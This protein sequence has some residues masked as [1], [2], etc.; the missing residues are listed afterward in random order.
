MP[1]RDLGSYLGGGGWP[2]VGEPTWK[3]GLEMHLAICLKSGTMT[4]ANSTGS[5]TSRISSSSFRNMTSLGLCT[6]GQYLSRPITTLQG[7]GRG[8]EGGRQ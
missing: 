5:I 7:K 1:Q 4:L 6:L 2:K 8:G 3:C